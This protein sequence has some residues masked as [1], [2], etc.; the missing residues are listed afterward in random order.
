MKIV[1]GITGASGSIYS[2]RFIKYLSDI[3]EIEKIFLVIS[4]VGEKVFE[5]EMNKS[6]SVFKN[7]NKVEIFDEKDF[8]A[9]ISSG[10]FKTDGM[11]IIPCSTSTLS[12]IAN[13][14]NLNLIHRAAEV[15]LK[16]K[17]NLIL[18][19]RENPIDLIHIKN[20]EK[21]VLSGGTVF[22]ASPS[23]YMK[24]KNILELV[25]SVVFK[26]LDFLGLAEDDF[27]KRWGEDS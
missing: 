11:V 21:I 16:E 24:P 14:I 9:P 22:T 12:S 3:E 17:R 18:V 15:T 20:M 7:F 1:V 23:F 8:F 13:G 5:Y 19:L 26:I 10:S 6:V 27:Y 25:D 4:D 2:Y